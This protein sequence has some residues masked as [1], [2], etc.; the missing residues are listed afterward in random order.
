MNENDNHP[1][2]NG[3]YDWGDGWRAPVVTDNREWIAELQ[4]MLGNVL[5]TEDSGCPWLTF[6]EACVDLIGQIRRLA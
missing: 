1:L 4:E 6:E 2:T 3:T 5:E